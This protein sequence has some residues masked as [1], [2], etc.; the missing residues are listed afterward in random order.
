MKTSLLKAAAICLVAI[1]S[2][3]YSQVDL[4][5]GYPSDGLETRLNVRDRIDLSNVNVTV[6]IPTSSDFSAG[7]TQRE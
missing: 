2:L 4:T 1:P 3:F 5:I 6:I 7:A